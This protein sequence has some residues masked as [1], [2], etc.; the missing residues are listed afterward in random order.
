MSAM[1]KRGL[2]LLLFCWAA[3]VPL[4]AEYFTITNYSVRVVFT[5]EGYADFDETIEVL[6]S[7]PRHG[8]FRN[9]PL[10]SEV[11]GT[12]VTRI[13]ATSKCRASNSASRKKATTWC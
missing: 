7:E 13:M 8:I 6:F 11:N 4:R 2:F 3:A 10:K 9:I 1:L 5:E 12:T